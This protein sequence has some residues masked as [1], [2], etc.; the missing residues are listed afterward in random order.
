MRNVKDKFVEKIKSH[1]LCSKLFPKIVPFMRK[2]GKKYCT[3]GQATDDSMAQA[4][5][6]LDN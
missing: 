3:A 4:H 2:C 5:C 1:I 6:M